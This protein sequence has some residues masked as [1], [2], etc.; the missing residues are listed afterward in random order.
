MKL[1]KLLMFIFIISILTACSSG[2]SSVAKSGAEQKQASS[3]ELKVVFLDVG[4]GDSTYIK[5]PSGEDILIDG[6]DNSHGDKVVSELKRLGVDDLDVVIGTHPDSDHIGGLTT[7]LKEFDVKSV[8]APK[9]AHTTKTYKNFLIAV[10]EKG[11]QINTAKAGVQLPVKGAKAL[12][13]SPTKN[14]GTDE[15]NTW[16]AVLHVSYGSTSFL[17]TGDADTKS[18][19]DMLASG[20]RLKADVLKVGHHGANTSSSVA[21]L[22]EVRPTYAVISVGKDNKYGHPTQKT[23]NKLN[24]NSVKVYRTDQRGTITATSNG[25]NI[26]FSTAK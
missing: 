20:Q 15:M 18:E 22:K 26:S 2:N 3:S 7:V 21:F 4:Q 5:M 14:Y 8:Y 10:K 6:G 1:K 24:Q 17:F 9:V 23:L 16:S 12:F 25:K 11:L 19:K 13:V